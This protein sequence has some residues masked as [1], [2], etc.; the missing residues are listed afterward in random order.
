MEVKRSPQRIVVLW[1]VRRAVHSHQPLTP[2]V[3]TTPVME[4][5]EQKDRR[6]DEACL[7][8]AHAPP[9]H[10]ARQQRRTVLPRAVDGTPTTGMGNWYTNVA[11]LSHCIASAALQPDKNGYVMPQVLLY[12]TGIGAGSL[13]DIPS[14]LIAAATGLTFGLKVDEGE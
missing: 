2:I 8:R 1:Y 14:Q 5:G 9:S 7:S 12:Q 11:L 3:A 6:H 4:P 10:P 13:L